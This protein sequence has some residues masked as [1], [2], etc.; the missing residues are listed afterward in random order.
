MST[1]DW[2]DA[3]NILCI[4]PDSLGDVL[5]CTPAMRAIKQSRK[6]CRLTLLSSASGAAAAPYVAE[7]DGV[8][9]FPAP[10]IKSGSARER[11]WC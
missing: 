3:G 11:R 5:M 8:I 1:S 10:W 4:R 2:Q 9:S 7:L 6:D